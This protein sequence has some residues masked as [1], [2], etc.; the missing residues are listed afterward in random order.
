MK[1]LLK[2]IT[3]KLVLYYAFIVIG[4]YGIFYGHIYF[5]VAKHAKVI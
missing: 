3:E 4:S 5:N 1:C 2:K